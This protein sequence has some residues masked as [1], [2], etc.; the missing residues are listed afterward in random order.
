MSDQAELPLTEGQVLD[1]IEAEISQSPFQEPSIGRRIA[2][3][4]KTQEWVRT[5]PVR[6]KLI[7]LKKVIHWLSRVLLYRQFEFNDALLKFIEDL[8]HELDHYRAVQNKKY[9]EL[10]HRLN[11]VSQAQTADGLELPPEAVEP[12]DKEGT[13]AETLKGLSGIYTAPAEMMMPERV[14]LYSLI[15]GLK[16]RYCLEIGTFRGGSATIICGAMDDT[17]YGQLVCVDPEPRIT[18]ETWR[19]ISHRAI[20]CEGNSPEILPE[21]AKAVAEKFDFALIDGDHSYKGV[22][23]DTEGTLPLL[24]DGAYLLFHDCHYFEVN[25]AIDEAL[26]RYPQE[27]SDCGLISVQQSPG[28]E[29]GAVVAGRQ[30]IWG[31]LRL[32]R[33]ARK[34]KSTL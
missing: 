15:Y 10:Q 9:A 28:K 3:V 29:E 23:K 19:Q 24:A 11:V 34:S 26:R 17:G 31:G 14:M 25:E 18:R 32:L 16:P 20:L 22:L 13:V 12:L 7:A 1:D 6:G 21:A 5:P 33:F 27:L 4:R 8:Y 30:V 2:Q